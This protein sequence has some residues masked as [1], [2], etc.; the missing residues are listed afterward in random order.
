[1]TDK[2][3]GF[4][5]LGMMGGP[6]AKNLLAAGYRLLVLDT[7]PEALAPV[8]EAGGEPMDSPAE[9][10]SAAETVLICLPTP[11]VVEHVALGAGGL[12]E[13][14]AL[15]TCIDLSTTGPVVA[16]KVAA[17]LNGKGVQYLDS[18][19][20]GGDRGATAGTL[21]L[22]VSGPK[23][24]YAAV[25]PILEVIGKKSFY[26]GS[27]AGMGQTVK[28]A[29]NFLS[30]TSNLSTA[31]ALVM[32]TKSGLDPQTML[33]VI[34]VSSGRNNATEDKYPTFV[35]PRDFRS[36][37]TELSLKDITLF[38]DEAEVQ[39]VPTWVGGAVRQFLT[40]AV[41]QGRG[42][43]PSI[44][45]ITMIEDWAGVEVKPGPAAPTAIEGGDANARPAI[46][47]IGLGDMG[48]PMAMRLVDAGFP[49]T[50]FDVRAEAMQPFLDKGAVAADSPKAVADA[51]ENVMVCLPVPD[52]VRQVALADDGLIAGGKIERYVDLSTTG[53]VTARAV[54]AALS[55][56]GIA[57]L[58]SPVSGG[59]SG[60]EAGTLSL[61]QS[62]DKSVAAALMPAFAAIGENP[63]F[64]GAAPGLGQTMKVANNYL[65]A[66]ANIACAE[67]LVMGVKAGIDPA[68]MLDTINA[69]SGRSDASEIRYPT[70]VLPRD[71]TKGFKQRLLHKDVKLCMEEAAAQG[72][73]TWIGNTVR[74]FLTY[75]VSQGTGDAVSVSLIKHI[76][77][78]AGVEVRG[79]AGA[80]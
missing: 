58:D 24:V 32:G 41:G 38:N 66:T 54:A 39:G 74:Q 63:F 57:C 78:W 55:E 18:P 68:V 22:M 45:L 42:N 27:G 2:T 53:A 72:V 48:G 59:V 73:P 25:Q 46:G 44:S 35:M 10:A 50:V 80:K 9:I 64:L 31:E 23:D 62:G 61:M 49:L 28:V 3:L 69:S 11:P 4:I 76:E 79:E 30:A 37:R 29:N 52:V 40:H 14:T 19:V 17:G 5:G 60:A 1:M 26:I 47:F 34:N 70:Y 51:V 6:M 36:M 56:K 16:R 33:D 12:I 21:S 75:A 20:S 13:G 65:S 15:T 67:A 7:R 8:V 43:D 77:G 71:F